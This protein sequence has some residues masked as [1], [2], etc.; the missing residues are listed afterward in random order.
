MASDSHNISTSDSRKST[1]RIITGMLTFIL[2]RLFLKRDT[3]RL[4]QICDQL[5]NQRYV[6]YSN[7]RSTT[8]CALLTRICDR[9]RHWWMCTAYLKL[10]STYTSLTN[11]HCS[12][13]ISSMYVRRYSNT[14]AID[15]VI[16]RICIVH[17]KMWLTTPS[18]NMRRLHEY[19][20]DY[21]IDGYA[22]FI[23]MCDRLR[24]RRIHALF[25]RICAIGR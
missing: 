3:C 18:T 1:I 17:S 6:P 24:H 15:Y 4:D 23:R 25:A 12:F 7:M 5:R 20:V 22:L 13:D 11:M 8:S 16:E 9:L 10:W 19:V 2:I 21:V 14:Y